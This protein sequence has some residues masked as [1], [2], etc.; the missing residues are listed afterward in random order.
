MLLLSRLRP[1]QA[2]FFQTPEWIIAGGFLLVVMCATICQGEPPLTGPD[3]P[4]LQTLDK[5]L[6]SFV[7]QHHIPGAALAVTRRGQLVYARGCGF[8]DVAKHEAV[9]PQS[10]FRI[11]SLSKPITAMAILKLM[12][13]GR[14]KL[15]N[16]ILDYLPET[17]LLSAKKRANHP[18]KNITIQQCLQHTA[19]WDSKASFDPMFRPI[20]IAKALKTQSPPSANQIVS[21]MSTKPTDF[22]AGER[23]A[24]SNF[25]YCVLG[26]VIEH[27]SGQSY[28]QYV[29]EQVLKPIS[30][31]SARLGKTQLK[32]RAPGEVR[33]YDEDKTGPS[34]FANHFQQT[35]PTP[36][37]VWSLEALD[38]NGGWI[39]SAVDLV[40]FISILDESDPTRF[41]QPATRKLL[42]TSRPT[43]SAGFTKSGEPKETFY[44]YGWLVRPA[45]KADRAN[46]WHQGALDGTSSLMVHR[47]DDVDWAI[48]FNTRQKVDGQLPAAAIE[49]RIHEA[50]NSIKHWPDTDLF[51]TIH[52]PTP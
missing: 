40:R 20:L 48:L 31:T 38:A 14:L 23:Y 17:P 8:A 25:G 42:I 1:P 4:D 47:A 22:P 27:T 33:Y 35:V 32:D 44:G 2:G 16:P 7:G 39:F 43:G 50:I 6:T 26:R 45:R 19:G 41:I 5:L 49:N 46:L 30:I 11:A 51:P 52:Q 13:Q 28:E 36:Y 9:Q 34:V 37:G 10:L 24:Y 18:W 3:H 15:E 12:E 29:Q 21:Y